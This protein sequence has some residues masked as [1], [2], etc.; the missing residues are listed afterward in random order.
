MTIVGND[1]YYVLTP[2]VDEDSYFYL[3]ASSFKS[4][5][6]IYLYF[7]GQRSDF[8]YDQLQVCFTNENPTSITAVSNCKF[9]YINYYQRKTGKE[10]DKYYYSFDYIDKYAPTTSNKKYIIVHFKTDRIPSRMPI[11]TVKASS[12][13]IY[14]EDMRKDVE[15][16]FS[17]VFIIFIIICPIIFLVA[18]IIGI[19]LCCTCCKNKRTVGI[20][21][22]APQ[23]NLELVNPI[24]HP[25]GPPVG[26]YSIKIFLIFFPPMII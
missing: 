23:P 8:K 26:N 10:R 16:I 15:K 9:N 6:K 3:Y 19:I 1:K 24:I 22:Y 21:G 11:L 2:E 14:E 13:D 5:G 7:E 20:Q 4:T 18:M 12:N 25:L 17:I